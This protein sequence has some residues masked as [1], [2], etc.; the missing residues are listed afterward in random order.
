[1]IF[2]PRISRLRAQLSTTVLFRYPHVMQSVDII[3][4][5]FYRLANEQLRDMENAS[6]VAE[7]QL[8]KLDEEL[9]RSQSQL[10]SLNETI[11]GNCGLLCSA[12]RD[13]RT[14]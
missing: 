4:V 8:E 5:S 2:E 12:T 6:A 3:Q 14:F 13:F 7:R 1:L 10:E 11:R 9:Q